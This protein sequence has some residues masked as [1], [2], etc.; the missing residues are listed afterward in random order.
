MKAL[1]GLGHCLERALRLDATLGKLAERFIDC[2][3]TLFLGRGAM[4]PIALVAL[5]ALIRRDAGA[6]W[7]MVPMAVIGAAISTW[8]YL[9]EWNPTW[10]GDSCGLFGPACS[11]L[12]FRTFG[13]STLAFMALCGFF[14]IIVFN[15]VTF[16]S[17][18]EQE[19]P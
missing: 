4:Y 5:I 10:E 1:N 12:W 15:T 17:P 3:H 18:D 13:F 9:I 6:R 16:P 8:H 7:Y 19:Q 11:D 2:A 14:A